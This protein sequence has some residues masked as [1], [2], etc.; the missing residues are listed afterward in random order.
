MPLQLPLEAS[1]TSTSLATM[2]T[3]ELT[4]AIPASDG[5][6]AV[7]NKFIVTLTN[8]SQSTLLHYFV[9]VDT[10]VANRRIG[11]LSLRDLP[12]TLQLY[13]WIPFPRGIWL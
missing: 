4:L 6:A 10:I 1:L 13:L 12:R 5:V 9:V 2:T 11:S 7:T 3:M 8:I